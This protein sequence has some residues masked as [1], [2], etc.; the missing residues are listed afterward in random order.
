MDIPGIGDPNQYKDY[1]IAQ[2]GFGLEINQNE[3]N[4]LSCTYAK[5]GK[6]IFG[7]D[8]DSLQYVANLDCIDK[9]IK[10]NPNGKV[11]EI[12]DFL[13]QYPRYILHNRST[14]FGTKWKSENVI[15][16][17]HNKYFLYHPGSYTH[18][19]VEGLTRLTS[20]ENNGSS[21]CAGRQD[22]KTTSRRVHTFMES[23]VFTPAHVDSIIIP[24]EDCFYHKTKMQQ[25]YAFKVTLPDTV[26]I[27][28]TKPTWFIEFTNEPVDIDYY[29]YEFLKQIDEGLV[30]ILDY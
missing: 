3:F 21:F 18:F 25:H 20:M 5:E 1:R 11:C 10:E 13:K 12:Q 9:Y 30:E 14:F 7:N 23:G 16:R 6:K 2:I 17:K 15:S 19:K 29:T 8:P 26:Q 22:S 27:T 28:V 4:I 24:S